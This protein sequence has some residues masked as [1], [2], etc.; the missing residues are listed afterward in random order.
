MDSERDG[1]GKK[2]ERSRGIS[3]VNRKKSQGATPHELMNA[4]PVMTREQQESMVLAALQTW[5]LDEKGFET[6]CLSHKYARRFV[7]TPPPSF[8]TYPAI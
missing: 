6:Y 1:L 4:P 5:A 8:F 3:F 2:K 7:I